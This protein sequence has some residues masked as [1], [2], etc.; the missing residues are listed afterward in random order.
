MKAIATAV[1]LYLANI[2]YLLDQAL[3]TLLAGDPRMRLSARMGRDIERGRC[4]V[5]GVFC[6]ALN[7][8]QANHCAKSWAYAQTVPVPAEQIPA[9]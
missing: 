2:A 5:C 3:N 7:V 1:G 6:K 8:F 4:K 9:E